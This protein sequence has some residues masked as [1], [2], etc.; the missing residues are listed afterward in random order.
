MQRNL[1]VHLVGGGQLRHCCGTTS[2]NQASS[3][4]PRMASKVH[5]AS[6]GVGA[7]PAR[8]PPWTATSPNPAWYSMVVNSANPNQSNENICSSVRVST[9]ASQRS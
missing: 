1:W 8:Y 4:Q 7:L 2:R 9:P 5:T 6:V 3:S